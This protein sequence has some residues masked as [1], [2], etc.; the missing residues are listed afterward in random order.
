MF[1]Y[2]V[3]N[4]KSSSYYGRSADKGR[5]SGIMLKYLP[6]GVLCRIVCGCVG[7]LFTGEGMVLSNK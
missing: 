6:S 7:Y 4:G 2:F 5:N 3:G 1:P